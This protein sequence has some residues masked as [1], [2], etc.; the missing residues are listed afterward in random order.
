MPTVTD[1][2][3]LYDPRGLRPTIQ[4]PAVAALT[5]HNLHKYRSKYAVAHEIRHKSGR[6]APL[7]DHRT[8]RRNDAN[9]V[10][11]VHDRKPAED[12]VWA[13]PASINVAGHDATTPDISTDAAYD[14]QIGK[15]LLEITLAEEPP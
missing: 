7:L 11:A 15:A 14:A 3:A 1:H 13:H 9:T 8:G 6:I 4:R 5:L 2:A 12:P 10:R